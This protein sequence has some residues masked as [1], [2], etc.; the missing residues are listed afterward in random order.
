[1]QETG[2]GEG[3]APSPASGL[4]WSFWRDSALLEVSFPCAP[5]RLERGPE[6][7]GDI[8]DLRILVG[9]NLWGRNSPP[10]G[11]TLTSAC[12]RGQG[13]ADFTC[14]GST[15]ASSGQ[16]HYLLPELHSRGMHW[17]TPERRKNGVRNRKKVFLLPRKGLST[18]MQRWDADWL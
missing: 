11:M 7:A 4:C 16:S 10:G 14:S 13:T 5:P 17:L 2:L 9:T 3:F 6:L 8:S 12:P 15:A 1:M 18:Q